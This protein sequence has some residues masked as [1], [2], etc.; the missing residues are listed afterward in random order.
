MLETPRLIL[1][2]WQESDLEP[3]AKMNADPKVMEFFPSPL[4]KAESDSLTKKFEAHFSEHGFGLFA[5]ELKA[6]HEFIGFVGL[7]IPTFEAHFTP[8]VEI[9]WRL[10]ANH[11]NK[12]YAT[13]TA[14]KVLEYGFNELGLKEIV[15][16][17]T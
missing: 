15:S 9:G 3:F 4:I 13:E 2:H 1:R 6:T 5:A 17:T 10:A 11:H 12:G 7:N 14:L 8:C 16:F